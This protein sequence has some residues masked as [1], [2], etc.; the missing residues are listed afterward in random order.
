MNFKECAIKTK[1]FNDDY[2]SHNYKAI[3][4]REIR[5]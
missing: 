3:M 4:K 2:E 1:K 5:N